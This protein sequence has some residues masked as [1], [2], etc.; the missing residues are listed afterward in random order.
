MIATCCTR[1]L[2]PE[3]IS[4]VYHNINMEEELQAKHAREF[5]N[6][7]SNS[8]LEVVDKQQQNEGVVL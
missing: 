8:S 3:L 1:H 6:P 5:W 2:L 7:I 4:I